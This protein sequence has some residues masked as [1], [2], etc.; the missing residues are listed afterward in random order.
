MR[1]QTPDSI[2]EGTKSLVPQPASQTT[3]PNFNNIVNLHPT[4]GTHW[5]LVVRRWSCVL[6]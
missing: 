2:G 6:L 5:V 1:D 3:N 4:D